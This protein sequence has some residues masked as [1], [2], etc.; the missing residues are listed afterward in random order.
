MNTVDYILMIIMLLLTVISIILYFKIRK[1]APDV[2]IHRIT[3]QEI[4]DNLEKNQNPI[5]QKFK[6]LSHETI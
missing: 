6:E 3:E 2:P 4:A 1:N 5:L